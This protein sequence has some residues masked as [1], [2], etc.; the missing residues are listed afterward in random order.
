MRRISILELLAVGWFAYLSFLQFKPDHSLD[1]YLI[2]DET[3][4]YEDNGS[5]GSDGKDYGRA[6]FKM[7]DGSVQDFFISWDD[8]LT[9]RTLLLKAVSG[10]SDSLNKYHDFKI[11]VSSGNIMTSAAPTYHDSFGHFLSSV[12]GWFSW[13]WSLGFFLAIRTWRHERVIAVSDLPKLCGQAVFFPFAVVP[14]WH[15]GDIVLAGKIEP[16][17]VEEKPALAP[18]QQ[19]DKQ[20]KAHG[21]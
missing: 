12:W 15:V 16:P 10:N 18:G 3:L 7:K 5:K 4:I 19:L 20:L 11:K 1:G 2:T 13:Y 9:D 8:T 6:R 17:K 21:F 14:K